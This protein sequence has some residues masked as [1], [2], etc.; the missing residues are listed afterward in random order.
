MPCFL[1][2]ANLVRRETA[3]A[4]AALVGVTG[5]E[6]LEEAR[7]RRT[8]RG[9]GE[10]HGRLVVRWCAGGGCHASG[11]VGRCGEAGEKT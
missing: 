11:T 3:A 7:A 10:L 1:L 5:Q 9:C 6:G 8:D 2:C 4:R